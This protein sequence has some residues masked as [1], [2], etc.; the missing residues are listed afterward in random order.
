MLDRYFWGSVT[1]LSPEAPVPIVAQQRTSALPGGAGNVAVNV[2]ALGGTVVLVSVAGEGPDGEQLHEAL[3]QRGVNPENVL[4]TS[5]RRTTVKT[6]IVAHGQQL[7]R[8]DD[9]ETD[10]IDPDLSER[11]FER[12]EAALPSVSAVILSDYAKGMLTAPLIARVISRARTLGVPVLVDPKGLDYARYS[13][14]YVLTPN[15]SEAFAAAGLPQDGSSTVADAGERL[16]DRLDIGALLITEGEAG[17]TVFERDVPAV[18][19]SAAARAVFDVTGAGDTVVAA[20]GLA[21]SA[22]G[23]LQVAAYLANLAGGL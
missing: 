12:I 21:L 14:A 16:M 11:L 6:R 20:M 23:S 8:V 15:R 4:L 13:G 18:H 22:G 19:F 17:M 1:R 2:A 5:R 10:P 9:E 3:M 7:L